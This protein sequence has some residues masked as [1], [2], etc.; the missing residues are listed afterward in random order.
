MREIPLSGPK[1]N[2]RFLLVDDD[3]YE[4]MS[5]FRW[6][7]KVDRNGQIYAATSF[8][9]HNVLVPYALTDHVNGNKLDN[10]RANLREA[11]SR[12][13]SWNRGLRSDSQ[14]G[15]K[16]VH[17]VQG[18]RQQFRARIVVEGKRI[19]TGFYASAIE[20]AR[21]Y[22]ALAREHYGEFARLNFPDEPNYVV[23]VP[24]M[25]QCARPGCDE[26]FPSR[27][28]DKIYCSRGCADLA[29][30]PPVKIAGAP[31]TW[32]RPAQKGTRAGF[33]GVDRSVGG[34]KWRARI[35]RE[36][37]R[38]F[39]GNHDTPEEAARAYDAAARELFGEFARLNF[40]EEAA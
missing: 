39:L 13:N 22:D 26:E 25:R 15:Y 14:T 38:L 30:M 31:D 17:K 24:S 19:H 11:T 35:M 2:G 40:P 7:A 8:Q 4:L 3:D 28:D 21:A 32:S 34:T 9:A 5:Q 6:W 18:P 23:P 20:A 1:G 10:T 12:Q 16:G 27:R 29:A 37:K 33:K 36:G